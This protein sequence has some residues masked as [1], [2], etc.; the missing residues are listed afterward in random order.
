MTITSCAALKSQKTNKKVI[1]GSYTI[2]KQEANPINPNSV[3][4]GIVYDKE[5]NTPIKG[6]IVQIDD[7]KQGEFTDEK[8]Q[9]SLEIEN[10]GQQKV[11]VVNV[12]HTTIS[13][14]PIK[15]EGQMKIEINFYLGTTVE[16]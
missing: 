4:M 8:G 14:E 6:A 13:T 11:Q 5:S 12:G 3:I 2:V 10:I 15:L 9:Y 1:E 16:Y 7:L